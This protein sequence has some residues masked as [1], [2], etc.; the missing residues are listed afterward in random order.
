MPALH[1]RLSEKKQEKFSRYKG[2]RGAL[3]GLIAAWE[4]CPGRIFPA[5]GES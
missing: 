1:Q 3:R 5:K 2:R 4:I